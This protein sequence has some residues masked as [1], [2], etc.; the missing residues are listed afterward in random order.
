MIRPEKTSIPDNVVLVLKDAATGRVKQI[1][2]T[3]LDGSHNIVTT[4]G[5]RYY[6]QLGA[7][8]ASSF[9]FNQITAAASIRAASAGATFGDFRDAANVTTIPTGG[10]QAFDATYPLHNDQ[11]A[12]NTGAG[13]NVTTWSRTYTTTQANTNV[14]AIAIHQTGAAA[15]PGA[16]V[17]TQLLLNAATLAVSVAKTSSDTL[18]I[19]VNHTFTGV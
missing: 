4:A 19:F 7:S 14:K 9:T 6:A 17:S 13:S 11:D 15:T 10:T 1:V 12:N 16:Q 8:S 2:S 5:N 3:K 18:Q